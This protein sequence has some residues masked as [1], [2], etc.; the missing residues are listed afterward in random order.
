MVRTGAS[1]SKPTCLGRGICMR[2]LENSGRVLDRQTFGEKFW[3]L[4]LILSGGVSLIRIMFYMAKL[5][6]PREALST[7]RRKRN[8][9]SSSLISEPLGETGS[10]TKKPG[11]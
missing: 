11:P 5:S 3:R 4:F 7:V 10:R 6:P 8:H 1:Y 9:T 2:G